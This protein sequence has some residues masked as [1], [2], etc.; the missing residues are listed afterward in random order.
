MNNDQNQ[1]QPL[2]QATPPPNGP[3]E[4]VQP[5][6]VSPIAPGY[7]AQPV[8]PAPDPAQ[9]RPPN[10][11]ISSKSPNTP[12]WIYIIVGVAF[13][14]AVGLLVAVIVLM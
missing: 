4:P 7:Q 13:A 12:F 2:T 1:P 9:Y 11:P 14:G 5:P 3:I 8:S 10:H 6:Q